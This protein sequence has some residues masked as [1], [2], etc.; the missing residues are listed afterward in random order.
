MESADVRY[1]DV[2]GRLL[3]FNAYEFSRFDGRGIGSDGTYGYRYLDAYWSEP[4]RFPYLI[5]VGPELGGFAL[6][7]KADDGFSVAE[8]LVLPKFRGQSVGAQAAA[9]L[10]AL[11]PGQW[12]VAQVP[13]NDGATAFWRRVIPMPFEETTAQDGA[14]LQ[15]FSN[16]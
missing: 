10:F 4:G 2:V 3:E 6:A 9:M 11:H 14:I 15:A 1:R 5:W 16:A 8:F 13:G 7:R 12:R